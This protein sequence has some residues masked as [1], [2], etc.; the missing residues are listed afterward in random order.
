MPFPKPCVG[1]AR[2]RTS[3][4]TLLETSHP[5]GWL[6]CLQ[7]RISPSADGPNLYYVPTQLRLPVN[8]MF[9]VALIADDSE[10]DFEQDVKPLKRNERRTDV[11]KAREL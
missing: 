1:L 5:S 10:A 2:D 6:L 11:E 7:R 3:P 4:C 8:L 9:P